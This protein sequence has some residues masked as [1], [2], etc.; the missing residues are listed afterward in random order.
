MNLPT[1]LASLNDHEV[2]YVVIGA[3]AFPHHG[4]ARATLDVD[5]LIEPTAD[6][7]ARIR[8]ALVDYGFDMTD[9][10]VDDL[11][12]FKLLI[13]GYTLQLDVHPFVAGA[14]VAQ[15]IDRAEDS[16]IGGTP[17]RVASLADLIAM[18]RAAGRPKDL[19]DLDH[20]LELQA[21]LGRRVE[22]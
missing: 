14:E 15:V 12:H 21:R 7:A 4:Y 16:T 6:N 11:R 17:C 13:R 1:L 5:V 10:S 22:E 9:V 8:D 19:D 18:K 3:T 20:L 2:V